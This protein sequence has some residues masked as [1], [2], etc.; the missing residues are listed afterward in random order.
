[1]VV[2][3][4]FTFSRAGCYSYGKQVCFKILEVLFEY[5]AH[6]LKTINGAGGTSSA[7]YVMFAL[8]KY[9]FRVD[10]SHLTS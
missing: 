7:S 4:E 9:T 6:S 2:R 5:G 3:N 10:Q 1:M 8:G